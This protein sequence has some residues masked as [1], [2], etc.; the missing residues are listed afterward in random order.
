MLYD[1][2]YPLHE[3]WGVL[4]LIRYITLRGALAIIV[5]LAISLVLG[6]AI[7]RFLQRLN[8]RQYIREEGPQAHQVKSGTPTMGGL[9]ILLSLTASSLLFITWKAPYFWVLLFATLAF[10]GI[11]FADDFLKMKRR[12]NLGLS[13]KQ[14][15]LLQ[16]VAATAVAVFLY[17]YSRTGQY[18][19]TLTVPFLK[20]FQP[21][22]GVFFIP[23]AVLVIVGSSNAVNLTDGLD[24]LAIGSTLVAAATYA[25]LTYA[26]GNTIIAGYLGIPYVKNTGEL[27]IFAA[28]LVGSSLGFLWFNAHPAQVFMGDVGSLALGAGIGTLALIIKQEILLVIVGGLFVL[29]ALSVI[30][31]VASYKTRKKRVFRCAPIHHHFELGGWA[32]T[33]VVVR[34]WILAILFA[35]MGLATLKI[36]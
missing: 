22:L 34:F 8:L 29:E 16:I 7:I 23:F 24:G 32:E 2:L 15:F 17:Q 30:V 6:P 4:R 14:K 36:R 12:Q 35:L 27:A 25:I 20:G 28:A 19:T 11:G 33:Q 18:E 21:D 5:A 10:G 31:Q 26:A 9:L 3:Y 13:A 1:L